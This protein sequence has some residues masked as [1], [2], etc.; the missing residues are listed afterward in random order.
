MPTPFDPIHR[1]G[2]VYQHAFDWLAVQLQATAGPFAALAPGAFH[3]R[4]L[5]RR[6]P[7][8]SLLPP[9][10]DG[11]DQVSAVLGA[12]P[13]LSEPEPGTLAAI[14]W[15]E[16]AA[17]DVALLAQLQAWLQPRG[18]LYL[19]AGGRLSRFLAER[20][21]YQDSQLLD[22]R[23]AVAQLRRHDFRIQQQ[24][25]LHGLRAIAWHTAGETARRLGRPALR[26]CA[27]YAMRRDFVEAGGAR[28]AAA[29]I[30]IM[31]ERQ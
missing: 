29:L 23:R 31:A 4:E 2:L 15:V 22:A 26:D 30:L 8:L 24:M 21:A 13:T 19:V 3:A 17:G 11:L 1:P 16:P 18:R 10:P 5:L 14:A 25:G 20:R 28:R 27:H 7:M 6:L 12:T 9:A